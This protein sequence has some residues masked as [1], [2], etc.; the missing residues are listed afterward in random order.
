MGYFPAIITKEDRVIVVLE[1]DLLETVW[2][3]LLPRCSHVD[4]GLVYANSEGT[5]VFPVGGEGDIA[6]LLSGTPMPVLTQDQFEQ[7]T[8][9]GKKPFKW[10]S[11][12]VGD[13]M[14]SSEFEETLRAAV[15]QC[16]T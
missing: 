3:M 2:K 7:L 10:A 9:S 12:L 14:S 16:E 4:E 11:G 1:K 5:L 15:E 6:K 8:A 13:D